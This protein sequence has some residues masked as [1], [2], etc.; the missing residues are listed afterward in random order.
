MVICGHCGAEVSEGKAF[1]FNCGASMDAAMDDTEE[2][3][4]TPEF[5]DTLSS[6]EDK[7]GATKNAP[8]P[9]AKQAAPETVTDQAA[10]RTDVSRGEQAEAASRQPASRQ[11]APTDRTADFDARAGGL[12]REGF[13]S[14]RVLIVVALV[15][16]LVVIILFA[17]FALS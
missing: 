15:A 6:R 16:L 8:P 10:T 11:P 12:R 14:K 5:A 17:R 7:R 9:N 3:E 1:C 2:I 4:P 13:L